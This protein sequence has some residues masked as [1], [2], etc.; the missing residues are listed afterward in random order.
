MAASETNV[1]Y[2]LGDFYTEMGADK[3]A[4]ITAQIAR[5]QAYV[6]LYCGGQTGTV[7]DNV[8]EDTAAVYCL[9]RAAS[10]A[11]A[12]DSFDV[13]VTGLS[14]SA[15]SAT[16]KEIESKLQLLKDAIK[17]KLELLGIAETKWYIPDTITT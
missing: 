9:I 12:G 13:A 3:D 7:V 4:I 10:A 5:A 8:V 6:D 1:K 15:S 11:G 14:V 17:D 16:S 2:L